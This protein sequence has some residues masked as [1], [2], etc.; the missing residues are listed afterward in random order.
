MFSSS[1]G[2]LLFLFLA[3]VFPGGAVAHTCTSVSLNEIAHSSPAPFKIED[4]KYLKSFWIS[5]KIQFALV[6]C[7]DPFL[8]PN[9]F[10]QGNETE[11]RRTL[12]TYAD[13]IQVGSSFPAC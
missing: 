8:Q 2:H 9:G 5:S 12:A 3:S 1:R 11:T 4:N 6:V 13:H 10:Y 7:I